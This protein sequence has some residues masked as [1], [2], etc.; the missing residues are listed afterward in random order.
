VNRGERAVEA[1]RARALDGARAFL[2]K[3]LVEGRCHD[4]WESSEGA[5]PLRRTHSV[6]LTYF[7]A[8]ALVASGG[9]EP[10]LAA[11]LRQYLSRARTGASY[12]YAARALCDADDTAFA[13][14]TRIL[15][16]ERPDPGEV[17]RALAP[18]TFRHSWLTFAGDEPS[19][20][21]WT[22]AYRDDT[23]V[24]GLHPEVHLNVLALHREAGLP[25]PAIPSLPCRDGLPASYHYPSAGYAGWLLS[26]L[27]GG[28]GVRDGAL[29]APLAARQRDDGGW[30]AIERGFTSSQ[31]T[32]LALLSLSDGAASGEVGRRGTAFLLA[33]QRSDG[34]WPG[35]VLW[36]F[37]V[38]RY[39]GRLLWWAE[40]TMSILATSLAAIALARGRDAG[41]AAPE[42]RLRASG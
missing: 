3:A 41:S 20:P 14:R 29:D 17:D 13:L 2:C 4:E 30:P 18:F 10:A 26:E 40:D 19:D 22:I 39:A 1:D 7:V 38:R 23:S 24:S 8:R 5:P 6:F 33:Q 34:S 27:Q 9:V 15:L 21:G 42:P 35:G 25:M 37:H 31:E 11:V 16:G 36:T 12:G 32:A 28:T